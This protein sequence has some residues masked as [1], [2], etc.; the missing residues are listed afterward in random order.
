MS[1]IDERRRTSFDARALQYDAVRPGYPEA[2]IDELVGLSGVGEGGRIL[3]VGAGTG[4]ATMLLA[5]RGFEVIAIEPGAQMAAVLRRKAAGHRVAIAETT[6]EAYDG[7]GA[8]DV[9]MSAQAFHWVAPRVRYVKA[10]SLLR[11]NGA[12][13]LLRNEKAHPGPELRA[14]IDRAYAEHFPEAGQY[15][16]TRDVLGEITLEIDRSGCF[17]P[18]EVRTCPWIAEYTSATYVQLLET[19][20]DHAVLE[21]SRRSHLFRAIGAAIDRRGGRI[22]IPYIAALHLARAR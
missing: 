19:Y 3:E 8:V 6:F 16:G 18:V 9:V 11:Q 22:A 13:A 2:L 7:D 1:P 10:A 20:S 17:G 15:D 5:R 14:E 21:P 12:L 4:K